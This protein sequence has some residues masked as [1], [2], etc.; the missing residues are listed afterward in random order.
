MELEMRVPSDPEILLLGVYPE[1]CSCTPG[2][3][4]GMSITAL[5]IIMKYL[6]NLH[7][8]TVE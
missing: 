4:P 1:T 7:P 6:N 5:L 3:I 2:A 8:L